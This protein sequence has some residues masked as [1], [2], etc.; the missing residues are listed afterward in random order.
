MTYF[1]ILFN[2]YK[3]EIFSFILFIYSYYLYYLS[4]EKCL[5]GFDVCAG[6]SKWILIKLCEA[7]ISYIIQAVLLEGI[8]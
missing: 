2:I 3:L 1:S 7:I 6:K 5:S 4:L 8:I